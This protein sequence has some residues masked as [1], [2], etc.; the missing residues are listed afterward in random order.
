MVKPTHFIDPASVEEIVEK[1]GVGFPFVPYLS[2][3]DLV[4]GVIELN[5]GSDRKGD[6]RCRVLQRNSNNWFEE[7]R[8]HGSDDSTKIRRFLTTA[9][10][11]L[12]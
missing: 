9:R 8:C 4:T 5:R 2:R 11:P 3:T 6:W 1:H 12:R 10:K 7:L